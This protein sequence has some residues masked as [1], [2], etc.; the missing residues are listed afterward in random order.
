MNWGPALAKLDIAT[1]RR[2]TIV[3]VLLL[4]AA[5]FAL[6]IMAVRTR[7]YV[8]SPLFTFLVALYG[9]ASGII[10][11]GYGGIRLLQAIQARISGSAL[12]QRLSIDEIIALIAVWFWE[13]TNRPAW[14]I[15]EIFVLAVLAAAL[16][17][18]VI[19]KNALSVASPVMAFKWGTDTRIYI[20]DGAKS[21]VLA[22]RASNL[23]RQDEI[24][25]GS[26]G[27]ATSVGWPN[28][29]VLDP[30]ALNSGT[31]RPYLY[32]VDSE[33]GKIDI[34]DLTTDTVLDRYIPAGKTP[35]SIAITPDG[36]KLFVSNEQPIPTGSITVI[37][38]G[39]SHT[40]VRIIEEIRT[41]ACPQG[42]AISRD[43]TTLYVASQCG[44]GNDPVFALDTRTHRIVSVIPGLAVGVS[45]SLD[46][47][48]E[49]LY[50]A[51]GNFQCI[52]AGGGR[53]SPFSVVDLKSRKVGP[54]ICLE[55]SVNW[56]AVSRDG[57]FVFV[58][59]GNQISVFDGRLLREAKRIPAQAQER[60]GLAALVHHIPLEGGVGG[61][62][63]TDD[64]SVYA[65]IPSSRRLFLYSP[66]TLQ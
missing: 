36:R 33:Q 64:N 19:G 3:V 4:T 15:S 43:G 11:A 54:T 42:L 65:W 60:A 48:D 56:I 14:L 30:A 40:N 17:I 22:V 37:D 8:S 10:V 7:W 58:A 35:R 24:R 27:A 39:E 44:G 51:R 13:R 59:N 5:D 66:G 23:R 16:T 34:I 1:L 45:V 18:A 63:V 2:A 62:G 28:S 61:I 38:I 6:A 49:T 50:A 52:K 55:T 57:D 46:P 31:P 20:A 21:V 26:S 32:V 29:L 12:S 25:I 9:T 47:D 41:V 53:G